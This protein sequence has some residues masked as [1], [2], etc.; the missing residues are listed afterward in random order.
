MLSEGPPLWPLWLAAAFAVTVLPRLV[1][2]AR[3]AALAALF[4]AVA[5]TLIWSR[6]DAALAL[7]AGTEGC[8]LCHA[9]VRGADPAHDPRALGCTAC[10]LGDP[11]MPVAA[12]AHRGLVKVPG[13]LDTVAHTCGR[14][15]C[16]AEITARVQGS[17]MATARGLVSVDRWAFGE[18][19]TP[20][21]TAGAGDLR[22]SPADKHLR[23]LCVSCHLGHLKEAPGPITEASRGGGCAACHVRYPEPRGSVS[24]DPR[25]FTH[26]RLTAAVGDEAC[27]G[28]HSRS[29]R[30]SLA[31]A[32]WYET[33]LDEAAAGS[34]PEG[35]WRKL[36]DG[37]IV[38]R[39]AA[40][41]HHERGL[42]CVD[43]HLGT[44]LMGDGSSPKHEEEATRVRCQTCHRQRPPRTAALGEIDAGSRR[45]LQAR[46][47][48]AAPPR[49]ALE[50][51]S[52]APLTNAVPRGDGTLEIHPKLGGP[53]RLARPPVSACTEIGG[54]ARL[55]CQACHS[56]W[57]TLCTTCHTQWDEKGEAIEV[58]TGARRQG[59]FVEYD[60]PPRVGPP[61][62]GVLTRQGEE[63]VEPIAPGMIMTLNPP[64]VPAPDPLPDRAGPLIRERTRGLRAFALAVPHTTARR[65]RDCASCH[66]DPSALGAGAGKITAEAGGFRFDPAEGPLRDGLPADAWIRFLTD[67]RDAVATRTTLRPLDRAAQLRILEV[68]RCLGCHDPAEEK[69]RALYRA[70]PESVAGMRPA[71]RAR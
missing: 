32:G 37:R 47:G 46:F 48:A 13:N 63:R 69:G 7:P 10:H 57:T 40:D 62:L 52:G 43:C 22:D 11:R 12:R 34:L 17:L 3:T 23:Q 36:M 24:A 61:A 44:E 28:C 41:V 30:I 6:S 18:A 27:F 54:H 65:A 53:P 8:V 29:A 15:A 39:A 25:G 2:R 70:Y 50:D 21:G 20:D 49:V 38:R 45:L 16:H 59:A 19:P 67:G 35:T 26:P 1:G 42:A 9:D 68:G 55:S 64:G 56:T 58:A 71:C 66:R 60:G 31:Y 33:H 14:A 4:A 5:G 51:A